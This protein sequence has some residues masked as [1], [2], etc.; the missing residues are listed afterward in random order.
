VDFF[1]RAHLISQAGL[2]ARDYHGYM[3]ATNFEKRGAKKLAYNNAPQPVIVLDNSPY[4]C[5]QIDRPLSTC[6]VNTGM[7]WLRRKGI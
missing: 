7:I 2:E 5:L 4:H 3:N 1:L 6:I